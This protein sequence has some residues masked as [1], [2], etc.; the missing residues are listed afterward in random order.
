MNLFPGSR[1]IL[2]LV[3]I[4]SIT[5]INSNS[6]YLPKMRPYTGIGVL[7]FNAPEMFLNEELQLLLYNE[8]GLS[9]LGALKSSTL[10]SNEWVF[11]FREDTRPLIVAARKGEWLEIFYDDAG[12]KAWVN[13]ER[14]GRFMLWEEFLKRHTCRMLPGL[15]PSFYQMQSQPEGRPLSTITPKQVFKVI[16]VEGDWSMVLTEKSEIGWL[17]W[18]DADGRITMGTG[19]L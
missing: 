14:A 17:K 15:Q 8:P 6:A 3:F 2:L 18:R 12:R 5:G 4:L 7:F 10:Q 19:K 13:P 16:R 1:V 11:S 9:R